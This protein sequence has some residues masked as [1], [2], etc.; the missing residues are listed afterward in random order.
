MNSDYTM[1][2]QEAID[3]L[4][5]MRDPKKLSAIQIKALTMDMDA[6]EEKLISQVSDPDKFVDDYNKKVAEESRANA[7]PF[8]QHE[9]I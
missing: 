3:T 8:E 1:T 6:L 5:R 4:A 9:H 2:E 7:E